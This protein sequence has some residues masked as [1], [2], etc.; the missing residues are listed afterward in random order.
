[1]VDRAIAHEEV[2]ALD[3][4]HVVHVY[5][6]QLRVPTVLGPFP[7]PV[8][9]SAFAERYLSEVTAC[10]D[11]RAMLRADVIPLESA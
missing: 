10:G 4:P 2:R 7:D 11:D 9:A 1:M 6:H 5:D 8:T 3:L